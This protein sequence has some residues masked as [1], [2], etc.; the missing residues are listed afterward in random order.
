MPT[1]TPTDQIALLKKIVEPTRDERVLPAQIKELER[2]IKE[3]LPEALEKNAPPDFPALYFDFCYIY[4]KFYDFLLF[5]PLIGK[6][7]VALGGGFSSGKSTFLNMLLGGARLLPTAVTPT[8]SVPAYVLHGTDE[9]A[10]A[11]NLFGASV[12]M[13]VADIRTLS[14]GFGEDDES[15][16]LPLGH[17][18]RSVFVETPRQPYARIA[19][20]DTPGY[21]KPDSAAYSARTDAAIAR[22][23]LNASDHILWCIPA[24][25]GA[26]STDDMNFLKSLSKDIPK[27]IIIT[28]ADKAPS[29]EDLRRMADGVRETLDR[30]GI[31]YADVLTS[32]RGKH[33][34]CDREA[35][36]S[37]LTKLDE[38]KRTADFAYQFKKLFTQCKNYYDETI[39][40]EKRRLAGLNRALTH[41]GD[42][43]EIEEGLAAFAREMK[44]NIRAL[45]EAKED[46]KTL[47]LE[48]FTELK[49]VADEVQIALPEPSEIDLLEDRRTD[50]AS[51]VKSVLNKRSLTVDSGLLHE[52]QR[53]LQ[54]VPLA[55]NKHPGG[56]AYKE[57]LLAL[58]QEELAADGDAAH[59]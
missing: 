2:T 46:L 33:A 13:Q 18:L 43:P 30:H 40:E 1:T 9:R 29:D 56:S 5:R 35:I 12:A 53:E 17:L 38:G 11:V 57:E 58:L 6:T 44:E 37:Y 22:S 21:S 20:L 19:F 55:I 34:A 39:L 4:D 26:I 36:E 10:R 45:T 48:F 49:A 7:V 24:D 42:V 47:Q 3:R 16:E 31:R 59:P 52:M 32:A 25:A 15:D 51:V 23:Q 28:K 41:V 50:A 54:N 14:H 8:T 27:L